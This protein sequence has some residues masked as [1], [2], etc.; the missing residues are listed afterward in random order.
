M[1]RQLVAVFVVALLAGTAWALLIWQ[2]GRPA[3]VPAG[4][5]P[6]AEP[7]LAALLDPSRQVTIVFVNRSGRPCK[8]TIDG[9]AA[10]ISGSWSASLQ[11]GESGGRFSSTGPYTIKTVTIERGEAK[12]RRE[13]GVTL[14]PGTSHEVRIGPGDKVEVVA[15][16]K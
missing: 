6:T 12:V 16:R 4:S 7:D 14:P 11:D 5:K 1:K 9:G 13:V 10:R 8:A 3:T 2:P 15:A